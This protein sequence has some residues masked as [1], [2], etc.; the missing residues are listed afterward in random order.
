MQDITISGVKIQYDKSNVKIIDSYKVKRRWDMLF[1]LITFQENTNYHSKRS[2]DS[3]IR[4]WKAHN[5]LYRL[6]LFRSHTKDCDL[7]E[8]EKFWRVFF[9]RI[10]GF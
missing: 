4:E 5:R 7:N 8:D 6:G 3:W 1:I 2:L 10:I 9:Y